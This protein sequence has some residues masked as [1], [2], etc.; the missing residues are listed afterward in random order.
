MH[1]QVYEASRRNVL[2]YS[3]IFETRTCLGFLEIK[4]KRSDFR[5]KAW[6]NKLAILV[7]I[8]IIEG[9]RIIFIHIYI[10]TLLLRTFR[11]LSCCESKDGILQWLMA[12]RTVSSFVFCP[13][14]RPTIPSK[15]RG[16]LFVT[17]GRLVGTKEMFAK[18]RNDRLVYLFAARLSAFKF[19]R[20]GIG[21]M[22]R[23][24]VTRRER[25][26]FSNAGN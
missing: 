16:D 25:E 18:K 12:F 21:E 11:I 3:R 1:R 10:Y 26:G 19:S 4:R 24:S 7:L 20:C 14:M 9:C 22:H 23:V 8:I 17:H 15:T 5:N 13:S 2:W 6:N